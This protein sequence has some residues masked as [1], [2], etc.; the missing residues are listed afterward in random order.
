MLFFRGYAAIRVCGDHIPVQQYL[1]TMASS[2]GKKARLVYIPYLDWAKVAGFP[3]AVE[4]AH[5]CEW[6]NQYGYYGPGADV[7]NGRKLVP[8][9]TNFKDWVAKTNPTF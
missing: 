4:T 3:G 5:M 7:T 8:E 9:L 1:D 6:F 2:L